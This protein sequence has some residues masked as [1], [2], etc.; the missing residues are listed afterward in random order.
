MGWYLVPKIHQ[1][2]FGI[3]LKKTLS[4]GCSPWYKQ[5]SLEVLA[6]TTSFDTLFKFWLCF[7]LVL[8][9]ILTCFSSHCHGI[10]KVENCSLKKNARHPVTSF[11]AE[12]ILSWQKLLSLLWC[13]CLK[14]I[15]WQQQ[16]EILDRN[17]ENFLGSV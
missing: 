6:H 5:K 11:R 17:K 12:I 13:V 1:K 4:G 14:K 7:G 10:K 8:K 16:Q 3:P 15:L 2:T 9:K